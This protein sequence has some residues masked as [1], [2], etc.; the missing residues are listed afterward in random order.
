MRTTP[1]HAVATPP[2]SPLAGAALAP[3]PLHVDVEG[4]LAAVDPEAAAADGFGGAANAAWD[5]EGQPAAAQEYGAGQLTDP[6]AVPQQAWPVEPESAPQQ[7][8]DAPQAEQQGQGAAE[9]GQE[10]AA[11]ETYTV[12]WPPLH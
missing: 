9:T 12:R 10:G 11:Q 6:E 5:P 3:N 4:P 8:W 2:L 7:A 1:R